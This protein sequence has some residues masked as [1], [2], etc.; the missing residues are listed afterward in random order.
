[1]KK[2]LVTICIAI[3][4]ITN[5]QSWW[6]SKKL[7]GNGKIITEN[8]TIKE[9]DEVSIGGS[10]D[11]ILTNGKEGELSIE[12]EE[13]LLPYLVTEVKGGDL[14]I[15]FK[16]HTNITMT[17]KFIVTIP[18]EDIEGI[19][20]GGSGNVKVD[21]RIRADKA[22]FSIGGSGNITTSVDVETIKVSIGG[23]GNI[24]LS[25]KTEQFK[26]SIA[27]SGNVN[28]YELETDNLKASVAGSGNIKV[29]VNKKIKASVVGSGSVLYK[30]NP[31]NINQSTIGSGRIVNK[32]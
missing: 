19:S 25:G 18:F 22:S 3:T 15:K 31:S 6:N 1:M 14:K 26:T 11:V 23:S 2:L 5:A 7:K 27:G 10:F 29:T 24:Y 20:L 21:K 30:G 17:K 8:R 12:G 28:A 9:F 4:F 16:N 13:N 32:N